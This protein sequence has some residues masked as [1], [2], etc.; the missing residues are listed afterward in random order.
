M[1]SAGLKLLLVSLLA[2]ALFVAIF[3]F[4][5]SSPNLEDPD[6]IR[7]SLPAFFKINVKENE[8]DDKP[9]VAYSVRHHSRRHPAVRP[10]ERQYH[11]STAMSAKFRYL[12]AVHP[13]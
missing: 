5:V 3:Y 8:V 1:V 12:A 6:T 4:S 11:A 10:L 9:T 2:S 13:G 7:G